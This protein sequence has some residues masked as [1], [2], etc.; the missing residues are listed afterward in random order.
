MPLVNGQWRLVYPGTDVVFGDGK[1]YL[2]TAA[3]D[4]GIE[5]P[6]VQDVNQPMA[7]GRRFGRDYLPGRNIQLSIGVNEFAELAG[8]DSAN[9]LARAWRGDKV[10]NSPGSVA[11]LHMRVAGRERVVYGR[12]RRY[13]PVLTMA[14][15][16]GYSEATAEFTCADDLFYDVEETAVVVSIAAPPSGGIL[17][18]IEFPMFTS[19][20]ATVPGQV[21]VGGLVD[22][23]P[24]IT[25]TGPVAQPKVVLPDLWRL[26]LDTALAF[27]QSVTIDTRPWA[28]TVL[29]NDGANLAGA[30]TRASAPMAKATLPAGSSTQL[31][32]IGN[33]ETGTAQVT[34]RFRSA[35]PHF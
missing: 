23:W 4:L 19:A 10:R 29:R 31:Q 20:P 27:D 25:I 34:L 16:S 6:E 22:T 32:F 1:P 15:W 13:A 2:L 8:M 14:P 33:D 9:E 12:P 3:P 18:P 30:L 26:E 5:D 35:Y 7:D 21:D 11:E 24:V 17:M 28:R